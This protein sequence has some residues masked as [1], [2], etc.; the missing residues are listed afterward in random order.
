MQRKKIGT[1]TFFIVVV[2]TLLLVRTVGAK[3]ATSVTCAGTWQIVPSPNVAGAAG[4]ALLS[5]AATSTTD[6]WAVGYSYVSSHPSLPLIEH[7]N[8]SSWRFV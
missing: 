7:W 6:S 3:A 5:V 8:G 1:F 2:L 4:N